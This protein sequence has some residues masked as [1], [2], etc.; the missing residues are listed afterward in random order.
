MALELD[1]TSVVFGWIDIAQHRG[2][3][4]FDGGGVDGRTGQRGAGGFGPD[5]RVAQVRHR[6]GRGRAGAAILGQLHCGGGGGV[7]ADLALLFLV[8]VASGGRG[9]ADRGQHLAVV[10]R[11]HVGGFVKVARLHL[12]LAIRPDQREAGVEALHQARHVVARIA[13]GDIAADG[14]HVAHLRIGDLQRRLPHDRRGGGER[15]VFDD[16]VLR[17]HRADADGSTVDRNPAE[18]GDILQVDQMRH[19]GHPQL[20]HRDQAVPAR[21]H[22]RVVAMLAKNGEYARHVLW[23][24]IFESRRNHRRILPWFCFCCPEGLRRAQAAGFRKP[25]VGASFARNAPTIARVA[26]DCQP[27]AA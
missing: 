7:V 17:D 11:C 3:R 12:P 4:R 21:H 9:E 10:A 2:D 22:P 18:S 24:V 20:H 26:P 19:L 27:R 8:S 16:L 23:T 15:G 14:A 1:R 25:F 5:R 13:I 6:D